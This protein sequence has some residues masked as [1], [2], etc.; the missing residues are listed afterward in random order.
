MSMLSKVRSGHRVAVAS[1]VSHRAEPAAAVADL[2]TA[3]GPHADLYA[4]FVAPGYELAALG[5]A[6]EEHFGDRVIGCTSSGN[7]CAHGYDAQGITALALTGGGL[8][9]RTTVVGPLD[10]APA[11]IEEA[12]GRLA[13]LRADLDDHDGFAILLTDGLA[14]NED[15]LAAGLMATLGDV[16]VIGGSAGDG[17]EFRSTAV[18]HDGAFHPNSATVTVVRLDAPFQLL[19]LQHHEAGHAVL[20]A[21]DVEPDRRI[22]RT[23]NGRPAAQAYAEAIRADLETIAAATFS[24][25]PLLL[26]AGGSSWIRSVAQVGPDN[27]LIMFARVELGD[28]LRVGYSAGIM[29]KLQQ[30]LGAVRTELGSLGGMLVF[31]C[32][33]RRLE[34]ENQG[35]SGRVGEVLARHGAVGFSTYGEQFN[36]M[37]MNQTL[38]AV[39]FA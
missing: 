16:P 27:T 6:L 10:D 15:L 13:A 39:A 38:V 18:Y 2:A 12:S 24:E 25:H 33:L 7:I 23:F 21:T 8:R 5:S 26:S 28:V 4:V 35:L 31:D 30:R 17:L 20:V 3:L 34:S 9:A 32:V 1:A 36:G 22:I 19:R 11:A 29:D 14:R 37:H